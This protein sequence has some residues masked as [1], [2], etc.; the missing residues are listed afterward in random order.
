[1]KG[2]K[3]AAMAGAIVMT[4]GIGTGPAHATGSDQAQFARILKQ[5][6]DAWYEED[7]AKFAATFTKDADLVTFNGD[8]LAGRDGIAKGMQYYFDNYI[9]TSKLKV[10]DEHI[11]YAERHLVFIVRTTC[12][13]EPPATGCRDGSR[14]RNTNVLSEKDG[15]WAQES[16][17]NTRVDP[18]PPGVVPVREPK[19]FSGTIEQ[20]RQRQEDAWFEE[21]GPKFASTFTKDADVVTFTA[22]HLRTRRGIAERMQFYF[23][24]HIDHTR[25]KT[26]GEHTRFV[27]RDLA[28]VVRTDCQLVPPATDCRPDSVSRNTNVLVKQGGKWSQESFQNTRY[29]PIGQPGTQ[30]VAGS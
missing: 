14:S 1:M 7:G 6:Y 24:N 17:Q 26:L 19:A 9:P 13:V 2:S 10:L 4:L 23:D 15:R 28:I 21:D 20:I 11:R 25:L 29:V 27:H 30:D 8:H 22:D 5:Q 12:I 3:V 16:F 18:L